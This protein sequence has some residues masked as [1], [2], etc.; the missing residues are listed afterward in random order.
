[1]LK[2]FPIAMIMR[3]TD[4][5]VFVVAFAYQAGRSGYWRARLRKLS[6]PTQAV[7]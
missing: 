5:E 7:C 6:N 2:R 1:M 3:K 4:A